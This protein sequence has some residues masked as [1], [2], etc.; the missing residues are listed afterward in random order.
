MNNKNPTTLVI[1]G[2]SGD[3]SVR[4]LL[5]AIGQI[6]EAKM[7][8]EEFH[9]VGI[10]RKDNI[11]IENLLK[12]T[13]NSDFVKDHT[14][15]YKMDTDNVLDYE[16][17]K[18]HLR[19]LQKDQKQ[20]MLNDD[21]L[22]KT[23]IIFYL[24]VPPKASKK[25]IEL[26]GKSDLVKTGQ[27]KLLLEKPFGTSLTSATELVEHINKYFK[28]ED[29]YRIDHYMAKEA[30][31]NLIVFR[32]G[33]SLFKR[34]WN[35]NFIE[36]I[37]II[38]S[39]SVGIEGRA[40]FYEQTGAL[41]DMVQSHLLQLTAMVLMVLPEDGKFD[42]IPHLRFEALKQLNIT[43]DLKTINKCA[44]RGQYEGYKSEV[45]NF[46]SLIE[47]F[48]SITLESSDKNWE[49]VPI[50]LMTGKAL[51]EK[52]TEIR[53]KYKKDKETESNELL[54]RL[55]P[56]AEIEFSIWTKQPGYEYKPSRQSLSFKYKEH[57]KDLPEAYEQ[58]LFNAI[59]SDH[60]LFTSGEEVL[61]TWR[62]L[63]LVQEVWGKSDDNIKIYKKGS[64][65]ESIS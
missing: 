46:D 50:T 7:L 29:V 10:T 55:Q 6:A 5:P 51:K 11:K 23:Q 49:G 28:A 2:I 45:N 42:Q 13:K 22:D 52:F 31:Q 15:I 24:S 59:N 53:I 18:D 26:L 38:V 1:F 17:L 64:D 37:E 60:S 65:I 9:I 35:K 39:E 12:N 25:I 36:S 58:V 54:L 14:D 32:N 19:K 57:Y 48:V 63:D 27:N 20:D 30:A 8:P 34:T 43:C 33:N 3:L 61:E 44:I 56:D 41:R 4:Y 62:I 16:K 47:T 21:I 40:N